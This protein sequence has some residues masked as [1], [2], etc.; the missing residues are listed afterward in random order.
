[1]AGYHPSVVLAG[2]KTNN[3]IGDWLIEELISIMTRNGFTLS[4]S[5]FLILGI[6]LKRIVLI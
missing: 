1:M 4:K 3:N 2:R 6:I 5:K